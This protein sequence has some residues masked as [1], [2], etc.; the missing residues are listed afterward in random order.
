MNT[1][2]LQRF[3]LAASALIFVAIFISLGVS[4][5]VLRRQLD[6]AQQKLRT[7]TNATS[8]AYSAG[9]IVP[10]F[11]AVDRNG[12]AITLGG[13][14]SHGWVLV[15]VHPKCKYCQALVRTLSARTSQL[16]GA[17]RD[18]QQLA[19]VSLAPPNRSVELTTGLPP[20]VPLYFLARGARLPGSDRINVVPQI[21]RIG[22]NG[23]VA[24]ICRTIEQC[25]GGIDENCTNCSS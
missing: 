18:V 16:A 7:G 3:A 24:K 4:N 20:A 23:R 15:V 5:F 2:R 14:T 9:E 1:S 25:T 19:V 13:A 10:S 11:S 12:R 21:I 22:A 8:A 6:A 17:S